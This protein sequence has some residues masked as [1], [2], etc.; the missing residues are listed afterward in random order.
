[1][2][3]EPV[4]RSED[5]CDMRYM[6]HKRYDIPLE[7]PDNTATALTMLP[8]PFITQLKDI[9]L[10]FYRQTST[11]LSQYRTLRVN[12]SRSRASRFC[13]QLLLHER[14]VTANLIAPT[15]HFFLMI[16]I[17]HTPVDESTS[18]ILVLAG[19]PTSCQFYVIRAERD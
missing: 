13:H 4:Q 12:A 18:H 15:L 9:P 17:R 16:P 3:L 19:I 5:G 2:N 7:G 8:D 6:L 1:M 14:L 11:I 10:S